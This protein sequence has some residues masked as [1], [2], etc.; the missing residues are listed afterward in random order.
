MKRL[1]LVVLDIG[2]VICL[3]VPNVNS[4]Q[5][6]LLWSKVYGGSLEDRGEFIS[7]TAN[8]EDG[9][10]VA[11]FTASF[12]NGDKDGWLLRLD[13][14]GDTLWSRTYGGSAADEIFC[15]QPTNDNGYILVG[16]TYSFSGNRDLYIIKTDESGNT[17]WSSTWGGSGGDSFRDVKQTADSGF[18]AV[19]HYGGTFDDK[20]FF[21]A[22]FDN[23]GD[24][25]WTKVYGGPSSDW[26]FSIELTDD[27]G[28]IIV[29]L[30]G[31]FGAGNYDVWLMK[32]NSEGDTLW[33]KT[34]GGIGEDAG[35][36][37]EKAYGGGFII[38]GYTKSFGSGNHDIYVIKVDDQGNL[39]WQQTYGGALSDLSEHICR[40]YDGNYA[41]A[42]YSN[43]FSDDYYDAYYLKIDPQGDTISTGIYGGVETDESIC[44]V[45]TA[46]HDILLA[47]FTFSYG[48]G[49]GEFYLLKVDGSNQTTRNVWHISTTGNDSTGD[50][51]EEYP[52]ATIQHGIF[53]SFDSDTVLVHPGTYV[54]NIN[55]SNHNII[56]GSLFLT[57]GDTSYISTTI[58][59]G[60]GNGNVVRI[61]SGEDSTT[62]LTGFTIQNGLAYSGAGIKCWDSDPVVSNNIIRNNHSTRTL[63]NG[64]AGAIG[65]LRS[66]GRF[67]YNYIIDNVSDADAGAVGCN[68]GNPK[69]VNNTISNNI[70]AN[71]G[72]GIW[73]VYCNALIS[74]NSLNQNNATNGGGVYCQ[75]I[76]ETIIEDNDIWENI[77]VLG[78]GI[79][80]INSSPTIERNNIYL[81]TSIYR[82]LG[83]GAGIYCLEASPLID[84][85]TITENVASFTGGGIDCK[86][87][88]NP[89]ITNNI[90]TYNSAGDNESGFGGAI[91]CNYNCDALISGNI[92][93]NNVARIGGGINCANGSN[94]TIS[95][96][97][98]NSNSAYW[99][100]GGMHFESANPIIINNTLTENSAVNAGGGIFCNINSSPIVT[101]TILWADNAPDGS[102]IYVSSGSPTFVY[103]DI[104]GG[105]SGVGNISANPL[106][107]NPGNSDYHLQLASP[108]ID[109][110][111]PNT[112][113]DPDSSIADMGVYPF[114][115]DIPSMTT[116]IAPEDS[117][118]VAPFDY[119]TWNL[120]PNPY[121]L[122]TVYY[123]VQIDDDSLFTSVEIDVDSISGY[124]A[125]LDEE[126]SVMISSLDVDS[127]LQD[128]GQYFWRVN[129]KNR[130]GQESGYTEGT[131]NY[132]YNIE[133]YPPEPF[134]LVTPLA[135]IKRVDYYT[136][137]NWGRTVDYDPMATFDYTFQIS[138]DSQFNYYVYTIDSLSDTTLTM[139]TDTVA[140][141]GQTL[142]W[143]VLAIDDDSLV[144]IGGIPEPEARKLT[145]IPPGDA[146]T[147]LM[148]LGS[149]VIYLVG[150][151]KGNIPAPDPLL[152]GDA[153]GD[154]QLIGS[155]ITR[156]ISYF[157]G[158]NPLVRG[159]CEQPVVLFKG[160]K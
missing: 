12:G 156:L 20:D 123:A 106:F 138:P 16:N 136:Y 146:N 87:N 99:N 116:I 43:S 15:V 75:D 6:D 65:C 117:E 9:F 57:T 94:A 81:N 108:C 132:F 19:G 62:A 29:G 144:R 58:I 24:T 49:S 37:I 35:R 133:N 158:Y 89:I 122:D 114:L 84:N 92:I 150:Y 50:G 112:L 125:A 32:T 38:T 126:V 31:S 18:I 143:R 102:E 100:G 61:E 54:E 52:F 79:F 4:D 78:S 1:I 60:N 64:G 30:T 157:K 129:S 74:G 113:F 25:L 110:G 2:I 40:T 95:N 120:V 104:Q 41:I 14:N 153:N 137:F 48:S 53:Q 77:A 33:T 96:N 103:C 45:E 142:Y 73:I 119:L 83:G 42:A 88:S 97:I 91:L 82:S 28:F 160:G 90:I 111:D 130:F 17:L 11:G 67:E 55:F 107:I 101:N 23:N 118:V 68:S 105:W 66:N 21:L 56:L 5:G 46:D 47:G 152:A 34:F 109:T 115:H 141:A 121:D 140:L 10:V 72:G 71:F 151:F 93:S 131:N 27:N 51:S 63:P 7:G 127:I 8:G 86:T 135:D 155:D 85:N 148:V 98:I 13:H 76:T 80:C 69:I 147:D 3:F 154:C 36:G 128:N 44:L 134:P 124:G 39:V 70:A 26:P 59:D 149:D 159:N 145:I 22:R 139:V